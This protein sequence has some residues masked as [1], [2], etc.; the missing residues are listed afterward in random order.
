MVDIHDYERKRNGAAR[1]LER[2]KLSEGDR[3]LIKRFVNYKVA[4]RVSVGRQEKYLWILRTIGERFLGGA[5]FSSL[6][7]EDVV[8]IVTEIEGCPWSEWTKHDFRVFLKM[9]MKWLGKTEEVRWIKVTKPKGLPTD[10]LTEQDVQAMIDAALNLRDKALIAMLY[11]GGFRIGEIGSMRLKD[12]SFDR[13]GAIAMVNGKTGMRR[14]RLIWSM[15]YITQ[16]LDAHPQKKDR[17]A[18][19]WVK[20]RGKR[21]GMDYMAMRYRLLE[22]ARLANVKKKVN[23]HNFRHSRSTHLA[24]RLTESQMETYLGWVQGSRM[25]SV[26]VHM[27][28]RDLDADLLQMYGMKAESAKTTQLEILQCPYCRT[29]NVQGARVCMNCKRPIALEEV[30]SFEQQ[31][32]GFF[33]DMWELMEFNPEL[34]EKFRRRLEERSTSTQPSPQ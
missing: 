25:P 3:E 5:T 1:A 12:L 32:M 34:K 16:W 21:E 18:P 17:D 33:E 10:L 29:V 22:A 31:A 7:K 28:G 11:E 30:L 9:F 26:Y 27:S 20:M 15:P 23:P 13:W 8:R 6:K 4:E 2:S 19:L 14:V 24:S